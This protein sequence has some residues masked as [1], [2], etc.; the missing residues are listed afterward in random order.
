MMTPEV[1]M[2]SPS[3]DLY[4]ATCWRRPFSFA[5]TLLRLVGSFGRG[6]SGSEG[7]SIAFDGLDGPSDRR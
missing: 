6:G 5:A 3:A 1:T 7:S 4:P 2:S